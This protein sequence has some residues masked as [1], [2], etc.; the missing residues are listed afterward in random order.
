MAS[1][2]VA[3][4][5]AAAFPAKGAIASGRMVVGMGLLM[6]A[7]AGFLV[8][9]FM[10]MGMFMLFLAVTG[11]AGTGFFQMFAGAFVAGFFHINQHSFPDVLLG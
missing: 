1:V 2:V 8:V 10:G 7:M 6:A 4:G 3:A 9:V 11:T 5:A